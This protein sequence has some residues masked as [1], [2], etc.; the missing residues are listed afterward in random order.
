[1]LI[2]RQGWKNRANYLC[3]EFSKIIRL[4]ASVEHWL[5][6]PI[7]DPDKEHGEIF[8]YMQLANTAYSAQYKNES[9]IRYTFSKCKGNKRSSQTEEHFSISQ[10]S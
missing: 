8:R 2:Q 1:M 7:L 6:E 3:S 9:K 5:A 10:R 4:K